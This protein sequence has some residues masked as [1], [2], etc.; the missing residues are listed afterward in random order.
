MDKKKYVKQSSIRNPFLYR[1]YNGENE[2]DVLTELINVY[3]KCSSWKEVSTYYNCSDITLHKFVKSRE[4]L[5][6]KHDK[7]LFKAYSERIKKKPKGFADKE[8]NIVKDIKPFNKEVFSLLP[9]EIKYID[10]LNFILEY[11]TGS[12]TG[13][14][15]IKMA[16]K[17]G[18]HVII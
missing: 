11:N 3:L 18:V 12:L 9:K 5:L 1:V 16:E 14:Q 13:N 7:A 4:K 2:C 17:N 10:F 15:L 6:R 8:L